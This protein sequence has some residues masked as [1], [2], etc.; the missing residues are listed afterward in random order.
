M[1]IESLSSSS[2][3]ADKLH[4]EQ[5]LITNMSK[6]TITAL[7]NFVG[8][9]E[10]R[11]ALLI[12]L[13]RQDEVKLKERSAWVMSYCVEAFPFLI[14][15]FWDQLFDIIE[16]TNNPG[17]LRNSVRAW[18]FCE[19]PEDF[20]G[21]VVD[22]CITAIGNPQAPIAQRAYAITVIERLIPKYPEIAQEVQAILLDLMEYSS[23]AI[24]SRGKQ[25]LKQLNKKKRK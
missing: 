8:S 20:E 4:I 2:G 16:H 5:Q 13:M 24:K 12:E 18:Q 7:V 17:V 1:P 6:A 22:Y 15:P 11:F 23:A 21:R 25:F 10:D 19:I 3:I 14:H 9:N